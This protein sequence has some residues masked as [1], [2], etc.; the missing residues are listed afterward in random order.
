M[1]HLIGLIASKDR[2]LII[3]IDD[4][5][6]APPPVAVRVLEAINLVLDHAQCMFVLS[7]DL[8]MVAASIESEYQ[9]ALER[10]DGPAGFGRAFIE[11]FVQMSFA[12]PRPSDADM[13]AYLEG[14]LKSPSRDGRARSATLKGA[15]G[16]GAG[17]YAAP[18]KPART[19]EQAEREQAF[20]T[21]FDESDDVKKAIKAGA[22]YIGKN[23]RKL[24]RFINNF[25]LLA[26]IGN[27]KSIIERP[28]DLESLALV[29]AA[30]LEYP[31]MLAAL[32]EAHD[33]KRSRVEGMHGFE[34]TNDE[35]K[36]LLERLTKLTNLQ[37]FL[38]LSVVTP[39]SNAS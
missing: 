33:Q 28:S 24:K 37:T 34:R 8:E 2:P 29:V 19:P 38:D 35:G 15:A 32:Q 3:L 25:R 39:A 30:Q 26:F 16:L 18:N 4:L 27:R 23:P 14:F 7:L 17:S 31:E 22:Y 12:I 13:A 1:Q 11:K 21:E 36:Q 10:L 9:P 20:V 5:D 6:R